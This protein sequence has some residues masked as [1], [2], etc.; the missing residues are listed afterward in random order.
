VN[1]EIVKRIRKITDDGNLEIHV[2]VER[3]RN[4]LLA[5]EHAATYAE[6]Q[7]NTLHTPPNWPV[8]FQTLGELTNGIRKA[9]DD[10]LNTVFAELDKSATGGTRNE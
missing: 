1:E 5:G 6:E 2:Q 4:V 8:I 10:L 3:L 9:S 7:A